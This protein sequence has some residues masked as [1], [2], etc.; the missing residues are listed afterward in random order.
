MQ[1]FYVACREYPA[2]IG[3][4]TGGFLLTAFG[5]P[6][7]TLMTARDSHADLYP[8]LQR[9]FYLNSFRKD[10]YFTDLRLARDSAASVIVHIDAQAVDNDNAIAP[11]EG[12]FAPRLLRATA[13]V[14]DGKLWL[15]KETDRPDDQDKV[16]VAIR[17]GLGTADY[18]DYH[19]G[20][21]KILLQVASEDPCLLAI[22][23]KGDRIIALRSRRRWWNKLGIKHRKTDE[24]IHISFDG[25][26]I[27][28]CKV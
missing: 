28:L 23:A 12:P 6:L 13:V 24:E 5:S 20:Q 14:R 22:M 25:A 7:G 2:T 8:S 10:S 16:L 4:L 17:A 26:S 11:G 9:G 3:M 15:S 19:T 27:E 21:T 18:L 1:C